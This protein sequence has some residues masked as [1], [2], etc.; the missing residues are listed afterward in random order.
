M[1]VNT[2]AVLATVTALAAP[3]RAADYCTHGSYPS[4]T[5]IH[6]VLDDQIAATLCDVRV[7]H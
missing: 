7:N 1:R 3:V 2:L 5:P 6:V 4:N